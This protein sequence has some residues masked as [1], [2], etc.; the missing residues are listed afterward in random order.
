MSN[1]QYPAHLAKYDV[2]IE[3]EKAFGQSWD[4]VEVCLYGG[5]VEGGK[6]GQ[7]AEYPFV[8]AGKKTVSICV[9]CPS[10]AGRNPESRATGLI[11]VVKSTIKDQNFD[12][13]Y[14]I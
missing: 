8:A 11:I 12:Q 1:C 14:K 13:K 4:P 5:A 6:M 3:V 9:S 7:V 2:I 10:K